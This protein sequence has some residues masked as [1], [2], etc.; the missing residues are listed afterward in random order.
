MVVEPL[1]K[2]LHYQSGD[3]VEILAC[4]AEVVVGW[5]YLKVVEERRLDGGVVGSAGVE[6]PVGDV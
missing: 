4:Y 2:A 5:S 3:L 6:Q 1:L